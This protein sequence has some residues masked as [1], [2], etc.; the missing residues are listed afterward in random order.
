[1]A[2]FEACLRCNQKCGYCDLPLNEGRYEMSRAEIRQVFTALHA[3]GLRYVF[4]QGG[5]PL[6]RSDILEVLEDLREIGLG[7]CLV[8]NGVRLTAAV[9]DALERL[10]VSVSIS[11]DSL[12]PEVYACIR[13]ASHL[14][15]VLAAVDRLEGFAHPKFIATIVTGRNDEDVASVVRFANE[16][17]FMP[18]VGAYHHD[19][20][21]YGRHDAVLLYE[22]RR[23]AQTFEALK[24][25][26]PPG[27]YRA[28]ADDNARW[29]RGEPLSRCDAG[30]YS[31]A[32]D[33]SGNVSACLAHEPKGNLLGQSLDEILAAMDHAEIRRCSDAGTCNLLCARLIQR[34]LEDPVTL[35]RTRFRAAP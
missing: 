5:E 14:D 3:S 2:V 17:G 27:Y 18:I 28:Y 34:N 33:A 22:R 35:A 12:D 1:M 25:Q 11:L 26:L 24:H 13:G 4:V 21:R 6:V 10:E 29:L 31:I 23:A 8:T 20:G 9:V 19:V 32:I 16:R 15:R 7:V 30:R